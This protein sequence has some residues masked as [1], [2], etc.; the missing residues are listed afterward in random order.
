MLAAGVGAV[1]TAV[2]HF[3]PLDSAAVTAL[4]SAAFIVL[5][6]FTRSRVSPTS[7]SSSSS[8]QTG[9]EQDGERE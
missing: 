5:G 6:L 8:E 3:L 9:S 4:T 7:P 1:L 2:A